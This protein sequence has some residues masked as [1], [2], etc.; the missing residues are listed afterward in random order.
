MDY[1][2]EIENIWKVLKASYSQDSIDYFICDH[3]FIKK[4]DGNLTENTCKRCGHQFW[5]ASFKKN[6]K[7][8]TTSQKQRT[9]SVRKRTEEAIR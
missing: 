5:D 7:I 2:K 4:K 6:V 1:K 8:K 9:D 3:L